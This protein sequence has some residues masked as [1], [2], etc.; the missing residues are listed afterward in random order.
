MFYG[1][2]PHKDQMKGCD[3]S[4]VKNTDRL[5]RKRCESVVEVDEHKTSVTCNDCEGRLQR[6]KKK[7]GR[8]SHARLFCKNCR[9]EEKRSK[10]FVDRDVNATKNILW[11]GMML[12]ARPTCL[13]RQT[14]VSRSASLVANGLSNRTAIVSSTILWSYC[15]NSANWPSFSCKCSQR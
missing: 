8:R 5:F 11:V 14:T 10:W 2:W 7:N 3:P 12:P 1:D 9:L 6:Y 13:C 4:P 15:K